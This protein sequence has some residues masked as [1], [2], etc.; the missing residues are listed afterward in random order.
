MEK[1]LAIISILI[2]CFSVIQMNTTYRLPKSVIPYFYNITTDVY[3]DMFYFKGITEIHVDVVAET[4]NITLHAL[5]L[6]ISDVYVF[7][8][9]DTI[10]IESRDHHKEHQI[11]IIKC[12]EK[13]K[14][15]NY[16][17]WFQY[18]SSL[19]NNLRGF[20]STNYTPIDGYTR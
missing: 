7:F 6:K 8:G 12:K 15:G 10:G 4:Y 3:P 1:P 2:F 16:K 19:N 13:L 20:Y 17:L 18:E 5:E 11:L 14:V 9:E